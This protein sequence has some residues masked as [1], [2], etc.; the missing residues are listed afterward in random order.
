MQLTTLSAFSTECNDVR[1]KS[2]V[3]ADPSLLGWA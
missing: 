2:S 1:T 3:V